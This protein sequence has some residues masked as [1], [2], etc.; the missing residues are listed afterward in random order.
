MDEPLDEVRA[1][2]A[3]EV[4]AIGG[5]GW[6]PLVAALAVTPRER[7]AGP[8]PWTIFGDG[9]ERIRTPDCDP[10]QLYRNVL[11]ALDEAK[12]LNNGQ[13]SFWATLFDRLRPAPGER[14]FHVG[15]GAG[16]Y[17]A[18]LAELVGLGGQVCGIEFE[19]DLA[20]AARTNLAERGNVE[21]LT[22]DAHEL[23]EGP[24]DV[25]VASCGFDQ[26][27]PSW[28]QALNDGGRLMLPLTMASR[29]PGFGAGVVVLIR[30]RGE[31][32]DA[33]IVSPTA[34][35]HDVCGRTPDA[36]ARIAAAFSAGAARGTA[37]V[38]ASLRFD[39]APDESCWLAG[40]GWW[41]SAQPGG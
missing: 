7:F 24:A 3:E 33:E 29:L 41:L 37:P 31:R 12:G 15:A 39:S 11:I 18:I 20:A 8:G 36:E 6:P 28:A 17:T 23:V 26:I 2:Y 22:G 30:R 16:Y 34:I 38:V 40:E 5:V 14:V 10:R 32:F 13:P 9:L 21:V 4:A 19:P 35:Y 25:I 27:P 1:R